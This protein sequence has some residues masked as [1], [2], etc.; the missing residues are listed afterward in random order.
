MT[1]LEV[2]GFG[3]EEPAPHPHRRAEDLAD[4]T[5]H[6]AILIAAPFEHAADAV[7]L[8]HEAAHTGLISDGKIFLLNLRDAVRIT[9]GE[10]G[11]TALR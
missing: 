10:T 7:E 8:M 5:A 9:S 4:L 1:V 3:R 11:I 6:T 2:R